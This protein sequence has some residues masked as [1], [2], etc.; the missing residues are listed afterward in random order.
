ML[1]SVAAVAE[2]DIEGLWHRATRSFRRH[3]ASD[4]GIRAMSVPQTGVLGG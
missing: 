1:T 3:P 2:A 4:Q